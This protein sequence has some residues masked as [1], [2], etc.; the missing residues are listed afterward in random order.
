[1]LDSINDLTDTWPCGGRSDRWEAA[2]LVTEAPAGGEKPPEE[3]VQGFGL[4]CRQ[5]RVPAADL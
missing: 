5:S 2:G 4:G 1:M 3:V